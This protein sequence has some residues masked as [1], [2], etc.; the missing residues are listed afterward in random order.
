LRPKILS[1]PGGRGRPNH[2]H[3]I[4]GRRLK[5]FRDG[6]RISRPDAAKHISASASKMSRIELGRVGLKDDDLE[7]LLDLYGVADS[8]ERLALLDLS[9]RLN[10]KKWWDSPS[11]SFADWFCSYLILESAAA[12][13]WTYECSLVPGLLQ[14]QAYAESIIRTRYSDD[15]HVRRLVEVR[16][17]RQNMVH[18]TGTPK[19]WAIVDL[20]ALTDGVDDTAIMREQIEFLIE[21]TQ[22][23][24]VRIQ[25]LQPRAG[26]CALRNDSFSVLRFSS[27]HLADVVYLENLESAHFLD[28][29]ERS[30]PY[31]LAM[32]RIGN[33]ADPP[34]Q[35]RRTLEDVLARIG[36]GP[37]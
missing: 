6:A 21:A 25:L 19:L 26:L 30:E 20:S 3:E 32:S 23:K 2:V 1:P 34:E 13:I 24:D 36:A 33:A 14:T 35:T 28:G 29:P 17:R 8:G 37:S 18:G 4:L 9:R 31:R 11:D 5:A 10:G 15:D 16:M 27:T 22:F 7:K 12:Y